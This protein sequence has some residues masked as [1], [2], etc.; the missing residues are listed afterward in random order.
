MIDTVE[1][2]ISG[3]HEGVDF[4]RLL[5]ISHLYGDPAYSLGSW[6]S[7]LACGRDIHGIRSC[8]CVMVLGHRHG[9]Y[10]GLFS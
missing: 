10:I 5:P 6:H 7:A 1:L 4:A 3:Y 2:V 8:C 9:P